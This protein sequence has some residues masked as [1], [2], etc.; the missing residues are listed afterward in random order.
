MNTLKTNFYGN[1]NVG[2]YGF[3]TDKYCVIG[4]GLPKKLIKEI[5]KILD[6]PIYEINING[7]HLIG[8]YCCGNEKI[9]L[10][11]EIIK[12]NEED[13]LKK[14]KLPYKLIKSKF[15]ALG[16]N[17]SV[18]G[19]KGILSSECSD[20]L[21]KELAEFDIKILKLKNN[22]TVGSCLV[23]NKNGC[24]ASSDFDQEHLDKVEQFLNVKT[25]IG[26]I[27]K[28]NPYVKSGMIV[29]SK[30]YIVGNDTTGVEIM[31]IDGVLK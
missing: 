20:E 1:P 22:N 10:V 11:P 17:I 6:V 9:L 12:K 18:F 13:E 27:N 14:L 24:L 5:E 2:L 21:K 31:R 15:S 29:N 25:R 3:A 19:N 30:G 23:I 16:N 7:S 26:S 8:V 28:G 4:K